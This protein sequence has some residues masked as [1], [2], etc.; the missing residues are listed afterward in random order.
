MGY[1]EFEEALTFLSGCVQVT[2]GDESHQIEAGT[3]VFIRPYLKHSVLNQGDEAAKL[4]ALLMSV[5]PKVIYPDDLP[6]PV[7]WDDYR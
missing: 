6:K 3:T 7:R 5:D 4:I 1:H 2:L